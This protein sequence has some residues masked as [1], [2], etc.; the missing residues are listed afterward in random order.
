MILSKNKIILMLL[1]IMIGIIDFVFCKE[2]SNKNENTKTNKITKTENE[3]NITTEENIRNQNNKSKNKK[4]KNMVFIKGGTFIMGDKWGDGEDDEKPPHKVTISSFYMDETEVTTQAFEEYISKEDI[5][6]SWYI[7][8][9]SS[10]DFY[11]YCNI[12]SNRKNHPVNCVNWYA[13]DAYCKWKN[14][15]LPTEAE[16]EYAAGNGNKHTKW[17][18]GN[19]FNKNDYCFDRNTGTCPVKS[20]KANDFG[21]FD[22]SGNVWE[23]CQDRYQEDFYK[24]SSSTDPVCN[25]NLSESRIIRDSSWRY[26]KI[27][28]LRISNRSHDDP[29]SISE[30]FRC[31]MSE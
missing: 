12:D 29:D 17:S 2:N 23:W 9:D 16:W 28:N 25:N 24:K 20:F 7:N 10:D 8:F 27:W 31:V 5:D 30:G 19:N 21:L 22:M 18:L 15:R 26:N 4:I 13:A 1:I 6:V 14:K 11:K 3:L